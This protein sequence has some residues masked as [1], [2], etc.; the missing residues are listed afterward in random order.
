MIKSQVLDGFL[1][2]GVEPV[3]RESAMIS[4]MQ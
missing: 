1:E 2:V 4:P 3:E